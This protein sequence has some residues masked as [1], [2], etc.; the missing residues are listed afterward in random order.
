MPVRET[1]TKRRSTVDRA[2]R[3]SARSVALQI[4]GS[5]SLVFALFLTMPAVGHHDPGHG[6][7]PPEWSS[8][9]NPESAPEGGSSSGTADDGTSTATSTGTTSEASTSSGSGAGGSGSGH[10]YGKSG[11]S[12]SGKGS[13]SSSSAATT[14]QPST[15]SSS[16]TTSSTSTQGATHGAQSTCTNKH[17]R[18]PTGGPFDS[19]CDGSPS[20]N[21]NGRGNATG[22]PCAGCVGNAD[23]KHP[24]GQSLNDHNQGYECDGNSGIGKTNPAH[25]GC[26][27]LVPPPP[28]PVAP[29]PPPPGPPPPPVKVEPVPEAP[30]AVPPRGPGELAVTGSNAAPLLGVAGGLAV[31]G[32]VLIAVGRRRERQ[33]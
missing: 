13:H 31:L 14:T 22:K 30:P 10:A 21:G 16:S 26:R 11:G 33:I 4:G 2:P 25:S 20:L 1:R 23:F 27:A 6:G 5:A 8:S 29:P 3:R 32:V 7:G 15:G 12:G 18:T 28:P 17:P 19:T 9:G 24:G